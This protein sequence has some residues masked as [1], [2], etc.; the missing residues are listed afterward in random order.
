MSKQQWIVF[1][2]MEF[3][4][5]SLA[6][7]FPSKGTIV[8]FLIVHLELLVIRKARKIHDKLFNGADWLRRTVYFIPYLL[9][10]LLFTPDVPVTKHMPISLLFA[11]IVSICFLI[12]LIKELRPFYNQEL[13]TLFPTITL[14][15]ASLDAYSNIASA[16]LQELFYKAFVILSLLPLIGVA[17]AL[18]IS[19]FLF[20]AEHILHFAA[21]QRFRPRDFFKQFML[22]LSAG[23][24]FVYS[25]SVL[26]P[27][28]I[29]LTYNIPIAYTSFARFRMSKR[30][31]EENQHA[32]YNASN[33]K[34]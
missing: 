18:L 29:H 12:P 3:I 5:I 32:N 2:L 34:T 17:P 22:S 27:I 26:I 11:I 31:K 20:V 8:L 25:G 24:L 14:R 30:V 1:T 4:I 9:A 33:C 15:S 6:I 21:Q 13:M 23:L 16:I 10:F 7:F 19:A 28:L